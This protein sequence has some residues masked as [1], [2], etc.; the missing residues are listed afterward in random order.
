MASRNLTRLKLGIRIYPDFT[1]RENYVDDQPKKKKRSR[2][3]LVF[4]T[5]TR[6]DATQD[7]IFGSYRF[8]RDRRCI[9]EGILY[10]DGITPAELEIVRNYVA[11]NPAETQN[12]RADK[13]LLLSRSEFCAKVYKFVYKGRALMA[14]YNFPF[15]ISRIADAF[16]AARGIFL[17][18]FSFN[19]FSYLDKNDTSRGDKHRPRIS[20]KHIN[21][22]S[23]LK[24]FSARICPDQEDLDEPDY[25]DPADPDKKKHFRGHFLDPRTLSF[26]VT[27]R[28]FTLEQACKEFLGK[29]GKKKTAGHGIVTPEYIDYNRQDV[30]AT[31]ELIFKLLEEFDRH[32]LA[33]QETKAYSPASIGKAYLQAMGIPSRLGIQPNFPKHLLGFAQ[34]AFFG[35]RAGAHIRKS[36]VPVVHT[37]FLSMYPTVN[38]NMNLWSFVIAKEIRYVE[39]CVSEVHAFLNNITPEKLFAPST[40]KQL[41]GFVKV[42]PDDDILPSRAKYSEETHDWQVALNCLYADPSSPLDQGLWF[43]LPDAVASVILTGRIPKIVDAFRIE[44]HGVLDS[45]KPIALRGEIVVDPSKQDFFRVVIEERKRLDFRTDLSEGDKKLLD[46]FLKVLANATSYGIYAEMN[47]KESQREVMLDCY[48][49]DEEPYV[50]RVSKPEERGPYCFP[51]MA[52]LITGGARLMLALLEHSVTSLGGTYAME[53]T[54]SMAIVATKERETMPCPGGLLKTK[55]G[56]DGIRTLSWKD[57]DDIVKKFDALNPYERDAIAGSVLK[58]E[59]VNRDPDTN[60]Q[61]QIFCF[62]ISAKRYAHFMLNDLGEPELLRKDLNNKKENGWKEHGL[63]H[64]LNPLDPDDERRDWIGEVWLNMIKKALD[65]PVSDLSFGH[66]PSIAR[67]SVSSAAVMKPFKAFNTAKSYSG[68]IKPFNFLLS[69]QVAPFGHPDG[70]SPERFHLI[71]PFEKDSRKWMNA[72]WMDRYTSKRYRITTEGDYGTRGKVRVKTY[73]EVLIDYEFHP[74]SKCADAHGNICNRQTLGLLKRRHVLIDGITYIGK[75]SNRLE[76]VESGLVQDEDEVYKEYPDKRRD[77]WQTKILPMLQSMKLADLIRLVPQMS[78]RALIDLRAGRSRPHAKNEKVLRETVA[79][80]LN[81]A[82]TK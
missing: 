41:T 58:V 25:P 75:E 23:A 59:E 51:P 3:L 68:Q 29:E 66:L 55:D 69:A 80:W 56:R 73:N 43:S 13:L 19:L 21:S 32:P 39:H 20:A 60:K 61:R 15:D 63:G 71:A 8:F 40:W 37:D 78:R 53:D 1:T 35:G 17:G 42:I 79:A 50:C 76:D 72:D 33:L 34:S 46:R 49:V 70:T 52:S 57:V 18:G 48:G 30:G 44:A 5:E 22:K 45:L 4:D 27:D 31:S 74:E 7:L 38:S 24:G 67:I 36:I 47:V 77:Q 54:D 64:L 10:G 12:L 65:L 14:A 28:G 26:A 82:A 81:L 9:E 6:T 16:G 62:A 2:G 11:E